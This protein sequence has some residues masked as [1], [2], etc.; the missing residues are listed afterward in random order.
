MILKYIYYTGKDLP[1][2]LLS[3]HEVVNWFT[4]GIFLRV[5]FKILKTIEYNHPRNLE[6]C[7]QEMLMSWID[8]GNAKW[9]VLVK[10]LC[11]VNEVAVAEKIVQNFK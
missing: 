6:R 10:V 8:L 11:D 9:S 3:T 7:R 1:E 4:L 5:D 2:V